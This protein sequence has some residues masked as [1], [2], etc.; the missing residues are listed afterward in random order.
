[1]K[2]VLIPL[3]ATFAVVA[4]V[5]AAEDHAPKHGG[6]VVETKAGDLELVAKLDLSRLNGSNAILT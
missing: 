1:M 2:H 3:L 5:H 4:S 6:V